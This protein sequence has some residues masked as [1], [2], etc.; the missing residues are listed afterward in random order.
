M[1]QRSRPSLDRFVFR[2][3]WWLAA[4]V[5]PLTLVGFGADRSLP[6]APGDAL[7]ASDSA[8]DESVEL[9]E[10]AV[11]QPGP[12]GELPV[13]RYDD[14][15][16]F[17]PFDGAPPS[18]TTTPTT[19]GVDASMIDFA[20]TVD[21]DDQTGTATIR[22]TQLAGA[23]FFNVYIDGEWWPVAGR[24]RY[25][26]GLFHAGPTTFVVA[27]WLGDDLPQPSAD[28]GTVDVT[29]GQWVG[30]TTL[31]AVRPSPEDAHRAGLAAR[32]AGDWDLDRSEALRLAELDIRWAEHDWDIAD[33]VGD[34]WA[35]VIVDYEHGG[36]RE[37]LVSSAAAAQQL[38]TLL[39]EIAAGMPVAGAPGVTLVD[40]RLLDLW[41]V[42]R[43]LREDLAAAGV[44]GG[45]DT[46]LAANEVVVHVPDDDTL[47]VLRAIGGADAYDGL[48]ADANEQEARDVVDAVG[49]GV[50]VRVD[51]NYLQ[52]EDR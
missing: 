11:P 35:G 7:G 13:P 49:A 1:A 41:A 52:P 36:S 42:A 16:D 15:Y 39:D 9:V 43:E 2:R 38:Q 29:G 44:V 20:C 6:V 27:P 8:R 37:Y 3:R 28:C 18:E 5:A 33:A 14:A 25:E 19:S 23:R 47:D 34:D 10:E 40:D 48:T 32:I 50:D 12:D 22:W 4:A 45:A 24:E 17:P 26:R 31:P 51:R 30:E 21:I 46:H